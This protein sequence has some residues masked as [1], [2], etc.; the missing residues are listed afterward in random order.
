VDD[1]SHSRQRS[2][3]SPQGRHAYLTP[4][5]SSEPGSLTPSSGRAARVSSTGLSRQNSYAG[6]G[7][8]GVSPRRPTSQL[9]RSNSTTSSLSGRRSA[10]PSI[11]AAAFGLTPLHQDDYSPTHASSSSASSQHLQPRE[12]H[13]SA[14]LHP[15][16]S[17]LSGMSISPGS[18]GTLSASSSS[19]A[20]SGSAGLPPLTPMSAAGP[21]YSEN[22]RQQGGYYPP[23][24]MGTG[25]HPGMSGQQQP[26]PYGYA[27][28]QQQYGVIPKQEAAGWRET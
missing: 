20:N 2:V 14:A 4:D 21:S 24:H 11:G 27:Y 28:Q 15:F 8:G 23:P 7:G 25:G 12:H 26:P 16:T 17:S 19:T 1:A 3:S 6:G 13:G 5:M 10:R 18:Q 22:G 9:S